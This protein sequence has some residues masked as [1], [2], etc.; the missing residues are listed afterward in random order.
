MDLLFTLLLFTLLLFA[1]YPAIGVHTARSV[2][3]A[4]RSQLSGSRWGRRRLRTR[5]R[6]WLCAAA[7][8][9]LW[10]AVELLPPLTRR[11]RSDATRL[12]RWIERTEQAA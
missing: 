8:V 11:S 3:R 4:A 5:I 6:T 7:M 12:R 10:P 1:P 2:L 9:P